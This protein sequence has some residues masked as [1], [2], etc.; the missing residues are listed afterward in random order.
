MTRGDKECILFFEW[1]LKLYRNFEALTSFPE[2]TVSE[3]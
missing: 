2:R 3:L 1:L